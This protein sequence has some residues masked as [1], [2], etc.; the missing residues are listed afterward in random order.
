MMRTFIDEYGAI[1][2]LERFSDGSWFVRTDCCLWDRLYKREKNA[3][4]YLEKN[5]YKEVIE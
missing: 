2:T 3:L 1:A 4:N 5:G